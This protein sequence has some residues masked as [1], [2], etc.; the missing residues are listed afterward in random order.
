MVCECGGDESSETERLKERERR[1]FMADGREG[2]ETL[3]AKDVSFEN[4]KGI[5]NKNH[6]IKNGFVTC[7]FIIDELR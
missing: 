5:W 3:F 2:R 1:S 4:S 6:L 7:E